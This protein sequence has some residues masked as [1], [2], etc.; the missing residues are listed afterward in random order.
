MSLAEVAAA[1]VTVFLALVAIVAY[2]VDAAGYGVMPSVALGVAAVLSAGLAFSCLRLRYFV[3]GT[4]DLLVWIGILLFV[5]TALLRVSW[6][7]LLPPGRGPDLT[8]HLLLVDYIEQNQHL[9]HDRSLDGAMG[10]MAHYTPG[11][12][13]LAVIAGVSLGADG[14]HAF[15]PIAVLSA[16]LTAAFVFLI[17]R[18][19]GLPLPYALCGAVLLLVPAQYFAGAFTHDSFLAQAVATLFA[20][21]LWWALV[22]WHDRPAPLNAAIVAVFLAAVFLS[23]PVWL[24]PLLLVFLALVLRALGPDRLVRPEPGERLDG[25]R[26]AEDRQNERHRAGEEDRPHA[27]AAGASAGRSASATCHVRYR[28]PFTSTTS[29]GRNSARN[30]A[31]AAS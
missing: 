28:D 7:S 9:V 30:H 17:G 21:A 26:R 11:A 8:H 20:V 5:T 19:H 4:S 27:P 15:F 3:R 12:H 16:A 23:W 2:L 29:P 6:P 10:E 1:C 14:L 13:L 18:R 22:N 25:Q 24:G 31:S